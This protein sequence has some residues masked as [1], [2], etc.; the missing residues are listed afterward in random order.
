MC[1]G[2]LFC[3][4]LKSPKPTRPQICIIEAYSG[5]GGGGGADCGGGVGG[6]GGVGGG[7]GGA[8]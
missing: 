8:G 1:R 2:V 5:G 6:V 7:G 3:P 4:T